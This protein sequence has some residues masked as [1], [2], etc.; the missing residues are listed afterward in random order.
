M[1]LA[2][3]G[4][5]VAAPSRASDDQIRDIVLKRAPWIVKRMAK[6]P[7]E[8]LTRQFVT[9]ESLP[10]LGRNVEMIVED[11]VTSS[12]QVSLHQGKF[13]VSVRPT[14][15]RDVRQ[16][17]ILQAFAAWYR[18]CAEEHIAEEMDLWWPRL[19]VGER[20]LVLIGNQRSRWGSCAP[21]GTLRFSW[22]T[23][24]LPPEVVEYIV[25]HELAHL[26]VKA[27]STEFWDFVSR[28]SRM[29]SIG[30][31]FCGRWVRPSPCD[32][33]AARYSLVNLWH[34]LRSY[35]PPTPGNRHRIP[36]R[37]SPLGH[38]FSRMWRNIHRRSL[39]DSCSN[40][41]THTSVNSASIPN[42]TPFT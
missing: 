34:N 19:G 9:G 41:H 39:P 7:V 15:D 33:G 36:V 12:T 28:A 18:A 42:P 2:P 10:Y 40:S 30:V 31:S 20:S 1:R 11:G 38:P 35:A 22:R 13:Q 17:S 25:V 6:L 27:H 21:D 32:S 23:M 16:D 4:I 14:L 5:I 29:S 3:E 24:M 8:P 37:D 26:T